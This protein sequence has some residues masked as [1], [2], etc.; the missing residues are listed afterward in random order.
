MKRVLVAIGVL[1]ITIAV[2]S[3]A[4]LGYMLSRGFSARDEPSRAEAFLARRLR[5]VAVPRAARDL[6]NSISSS[7]EAL[8]QAM[9]HFADHCAFCHGND[10]SG[11]TPIGKGLYPK[12][13]DMR[14]AGTQDL[15]DGEL[16]YIIQNGVRFTGMPA[17]GES[18]TANDP[19]SWKLV[20]FIRHLPQITDEELNR[21]K[22]M[23][24]K[25]P[26]DLR[27][28]EEI[29]RFLEGEDNL[30]SNNNHKHH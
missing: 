2:A 11:N 19:D 20:I 7:P 21:M 22:E 27:E 8:L 26:A 5:H 15:S 1:I 25:T 30:P 9:E 14:Q 16:Y 12:P 18:E 3:A 4:A 13:P 6:P 10:G 28:E 17:F 23:N 29:Q 24:P